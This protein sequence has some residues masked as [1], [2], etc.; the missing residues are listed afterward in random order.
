MMTVTS[1]LTLAGHCTEC[2]VFI[3]M[4]CIKF[5]GVIS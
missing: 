4:A 5:A 3:S 1:L 2:E